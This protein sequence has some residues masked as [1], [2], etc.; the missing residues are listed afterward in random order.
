[1]KVNTTKKLVD[2]Q[3]VV[4]VDGSRYNWLVISDLDMFFQR[5][6]FPLLDRY[7]TVSVWLVHMLQSIVIHIACTCCSYI[8]LFSRQYCTEKEKKINCFGNYDGGTWENEDM[9]LQ[10]K[11]FRNCYGRDILLSWTDIE[12][13]MP[14]GN[15]A[16]Y[17][18]NFVCD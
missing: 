11:L 4:T 2:G 3:Q 17:R 18:I 10:R 14:N 7:S 16:Q 6:P 15:C 8:S 1:M 12:W 9:R 13:K 5:N